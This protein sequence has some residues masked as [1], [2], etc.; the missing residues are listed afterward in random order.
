[1]WMRSH[2]VHNVQ[3]PVSISDKTSYCKI[4]RSL[5]AARFASRIVRSLCNSTGT[6]EV[7]LPMGLS[8]FKVMRY[9]K[10]TIS[11]LRDFTRTHDK[12]SYRLMICNYINYKRFYITVAW[13]RDST[14]DYVKRKGRKHK[15]CI[16]WLWNKGTGWQTET[17][18]YSP[19]PYGKGGEQ[20]CCTRRQ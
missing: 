1:M 3:G 18:P 6:S 16:R 13:G 8:N 17:I 15:Y 5:E 19:V 9:S 11:R 2:S 12:T 10:L 20:K 14:N 7:L 4:L